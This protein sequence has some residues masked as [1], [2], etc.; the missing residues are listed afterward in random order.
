MPVST[1]QANH[2]VGISFVLTDVEDGTVLDT[3]PHD[4]PMWFIQGSGHML[5]AV[6]EALMGKEVGATV[7][8]EL[9][10]DD[11]FGGYEDDLVHDIPREFIPDDIELELG[12]PFMLEM[13]GGPS[14]QRPFFVTEFDD[15]MVRLDGNHPLAG[16]AIRF[17][18]E[19]CDLRESTEEERVHGHVHGPGGHHHH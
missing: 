6:E 3:A 11:A 16:R 4:D 15:Q 1:I 17:Q 14:T 5:P 18:I 2:A 10:G 7:D 9:S 12:M 19:V 13:P 8:L